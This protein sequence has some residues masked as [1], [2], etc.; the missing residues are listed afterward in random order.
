MAGGSNSN[1]NYKK[2]SRSNGLR[3]KEAYSTM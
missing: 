2:K 3:L 1:G